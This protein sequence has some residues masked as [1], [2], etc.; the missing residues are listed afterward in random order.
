[1]PDLRQPLRTWAARLQH[2]RAMLE[3]AALG[4]PEVSDRRVVQLGPE[5]LAQ[6]LDRP[7]V[8]LALLA[9]GVGVERRA[10]AALRPPHLAQRPVE[11][12]GADL[13]QP[14]LARDLPAVEVGP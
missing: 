1:A 8:E 7:N 11:R 6:L 9:L 14:V 5:R 4:R 13:D 2:V 10:E 12:L 3:V